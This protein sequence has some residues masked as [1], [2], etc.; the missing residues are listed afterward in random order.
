V[1]IWSSGMIAGNSAPHL[2]IW[3]AFHFNIP[4]CLKGRNIMTSALALHEVLHETKRSKK[5]KGDL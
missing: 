4:Y 5:N 3:L 2:S 1:G